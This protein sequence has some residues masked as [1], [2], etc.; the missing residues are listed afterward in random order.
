MRWDEDS[1]GIRGDSREGGAPLKG[2]PSENLAEVRKS[3]CLANVCGGDIGAGIR[4]KL[5]YRVQGL[6]GLPEMNISNPSRLC[7]PEERVAGG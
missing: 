2:R 5:L 7:T 6:D 4:G 3:G 1:G